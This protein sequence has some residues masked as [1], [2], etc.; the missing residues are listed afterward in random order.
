MGSFQYGKYPLVCFLDAAFSLGITQVELWAAAPHLCP[1][2]VSAET[3]K[4]IRQMLR[5]RGLSVCCLTPEQCSYP[6]N[7]AAREEELREA[8]LRY[9]TAAIDMALEL[10]CSRVLITAGSGYYNEPKEEGWK[11]AENSLYQLASY[12]LCHKVELVLETL[13]P[14]SSNLVNTPQEQRRMIASMPA[15][16]MSA[17]LDLGQMAY[18]GQEL[19]AYLEHGN[20]LTYVHLQD[21]GAA[22]HMAL[23]DGALSLE[24]YLEQ[25]EKA[26]YRGLYSFE[27]NDARYR[28]NPQQADRQSIEWLKNHGILCD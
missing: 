20:L 13:T 15:G 21:S 18:M 14:L 23:G 11:R 27:F 3:K 22:I 9:F 10:E 17:M 6:I 19:S 16:S 4:K 28:Q 25:L 1:G 12:G 7:L 8:S 24:T 2:L 5:E 26:G